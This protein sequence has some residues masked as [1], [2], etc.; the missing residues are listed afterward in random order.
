MKKGDD[1][2]GKESQ[3]ISDIKSAIKIENPDDKWKQGQ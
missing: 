2:S 3:F 1:F